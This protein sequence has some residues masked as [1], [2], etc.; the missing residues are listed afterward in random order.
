MCLSSPSHLKIF[1]E[2]LEFICVDNN[3]HA[4]HLRQPELGIVNAGEADFL[5]SPCRICFPRTEITPRVDGDVGAGV[6]WRTAGREKAK[7]WKGEYRADRG[8]TRTGRGIQVEEGKQMKAGKKQ[9]TIFSSFRYFLS[10]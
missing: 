5:P 2:V 9:Y 7:S 4:A 6:A 3:V 8:E 10:F 1:D